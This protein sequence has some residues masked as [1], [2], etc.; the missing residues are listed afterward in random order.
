MAVKNKVTHRIVINTI[1]QAI[2]DPM[3]R[4]MIP[5]YQREGQ[6]IYSVDLTSEEVIRMMS[7]LVDLS[8]GRDERNY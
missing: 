2:E 3:D 8:R 1:N 5:H 7:F 4:G 6:Q